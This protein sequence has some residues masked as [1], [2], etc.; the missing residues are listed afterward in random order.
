VSLRQNALILILLT[1]LLA[2][3]GDWSATAPLGRWWRLP[4]ALLLLG[5]AYEGVV[6]AR[7]GLVVA[8]RGAAR[9]RL[10]RPQTL[11]LL[12]QHRLHRTLTIETA[13]T[14]P[15][16]FAGARGV[17]RL[18]IG[19][20]GAELST[21]AAPRRLGHYRWPTVPVRVAGP[22]HLAWWSRPLSSSFEIEVV[23]DSVSGIE[24]AAGS[25]QLGSRQMVS[26]VGA[27][28][29]IL[30]LRDY[31]RGDALRLIDWKASA[32]RRR[33]ISRD[34]SEDQ[35]LEVFILID[36]G[37]ASALGAGEVDRLSLFVNVAA[38]L[39]QRASALDDE[40][41]LLLFAAEPLAVSPPARGP[42]AVARIR[43]LL[44]AA[45][46]QG[47]ESNP[48]LAA[49]RVRSLARRRSLIVMLTDLDDA[50]SAGQLAA[51]V[52]LL[53]P[54]HFPFIAG[55]D[56]ARIRRVAEGPAAD[57][58]G[59]Y[60]ALAAQEQRRTITANVEALR[61]RGAAA[62]LAPP[63]RLDRAVFEAYLGFRQ[64]RR[65]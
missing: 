9:W 55:L 44:T 24:A 25:A 10:A 32:R 4:A 40:V 43:G 26:A 23:P 5:L 61:T 59:A 27:G 19:E 53:T 36:A 62:L 49:A 12:F 58:A 31:R 17:Q 45:R 14:A 60:R 39:A 2:I 37:R 15:P 38:R 42:A 22:L 34:F 29:E 33:L 11:R 56:S 7:S 3:V 63:E 50:S 47:G 48:V 57:A 35:H 16:E 30:Q 1:G 18:I 21:T 6:V 51:A 46:V 54:K 8:L 65:I 41:G 52:R 20:E 13:L 28:A 64:R